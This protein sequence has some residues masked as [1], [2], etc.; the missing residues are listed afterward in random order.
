[1][2]YESG[3]DAEAETWLRRAAD[4]GGGADSTFAKYDLANLCAMRGDTAEAETWLRRAADEGTEEQ[5][6]GAVHGDLQFLLDFIGAFS[7]PS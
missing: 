3:D 4:A 7:P 1:M 2:F 6:G 5:G